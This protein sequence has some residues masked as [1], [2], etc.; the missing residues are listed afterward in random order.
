MNNVTVFVI[1][2][3]EE[4]L[5]ECLSAIENQTFKKIENFSVEIISNVYPMSEAFNE[6]HR[7]SKTPFF[8]QVDADVILKP[9]AVEQLFDGI[10]NTTFLTYAVHAPLFEEGFGVG[11]SVRCWRKDFFKLFPFQDCRT[12][13]RNLYKRARWFFFKRKGLKNVIGV[14][15]PR[16]SLFTEYLKTKSDVEKWR[17][18]KRKAKKYCLPLL[19][20]MFENRE[21]EKIRIFGAILG[22]LTGN[23]RVQKSKDNSIEQERLTSL[24]RLLSLD[25][26]E[27]LKFHDSFKYDSVF[28]ERITLAYEGS[29]QKRLLSID[30]LFDM[31][32]FENINDPQK[33]IIN[34]IMK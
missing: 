5:D 19:R 2:T 3:G 12:V 6:M 17:F 4:S 13:D 24:L 7:R 32:V 26:L 28:E 27:N 10:K 22:C 31:F 15:K 18:L 34:C 9:D 23:D 8:I 30:L 20:K 14:H 16:H 33:R 1:S 25:S 21:E 29:D 11:G